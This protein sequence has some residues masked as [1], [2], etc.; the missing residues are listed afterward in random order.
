MRTTRHLCVLSAIVVLLSVAIWSI[1]GREIFTRWPDQKLA[2]ADA[3]RSELERDLLS[4]IGFESA[5]ERA[6]HPDIQSRF[7]LGLLPGG[8]TPLHLVSVASAVLA[9]AALSLSAVLLSARC[10]RRRS[11]S[12]ARDPAPSTHT[13]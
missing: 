8:F 9:A 2:A 10:R 13:T 1:T 11:P 4:D 7:A 12:D 6:P 5:D 3:P